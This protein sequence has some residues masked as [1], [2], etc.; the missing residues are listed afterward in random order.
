L[1]DVLAGIFSRQIVSAKVEPVRAVLDS[2][3]AKKHPLRI[4]LAEDNAVNQKLALRLLEQMGYRADVASNGLEAI[5]SVERQTYDAVLMDVQ[6]PEMD[7]LDATRAIRKL[8]TLTQPRIVAMTANAMQGDREMCLA[9]GMDDYISK[10]I[11]VIELIDA[12]NKIVPSIQTLQVKKEMS[13]LKRKINS[14]DGKSDPVRRPASKPA[15]K[16]KGLKKPAGG[17]TAVKKRTSG[18]AKKK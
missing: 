18:Q 11:R 2:E 5:E 13:I 14:I 8:K 7:G 9:A 6:M 17:K 10:P 12:L 16:G 3:F 4:L 1:F 15:P